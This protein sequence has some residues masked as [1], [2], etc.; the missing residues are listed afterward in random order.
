MAG[1]LRIA[2][3]AASLAVPASAGALALE[4][5]GTYSNPAYVAFEPGNLERV[6]VVELGGTVRVTEG[7]STSTF[8]DL[9]ADADLVLPGG[10]RGLFSIAFAPDYESSGH[11]YAFYAGTVAAGGDAGGSCTSTS[12]VRGRT[13]RGNARQP[14]AGAH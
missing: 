7:G 12:S 10:E 4:P 11:L 2:I 5:V 1:R 8:L 6:Y 9:N 14:A 3:V 13:P